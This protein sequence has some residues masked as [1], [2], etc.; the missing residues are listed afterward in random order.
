MK[1][2]DTIPIIT[3]LEQISYFL[4][5]YI[6]YSKRKYP[7]QQSDIKVLPSFLYSFITG[8]IVCFIYVER[9]LGNIFSFNTSNNPTPPHT[10][11]QDN[12]QRCT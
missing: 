6:T 10:L 9:K 11:S 2:R 8:M 1:R 4:T 5:D 12:I 3:L 7:L